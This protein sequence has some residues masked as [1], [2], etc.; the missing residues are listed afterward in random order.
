MAWNLPA[1]HVLEQP[2]KEIQILDLHNVNVLFQDLDFIEL[3]FWNL[4]CGSWRS[5]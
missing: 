2:V 1:S 4:T 5:W 3:N